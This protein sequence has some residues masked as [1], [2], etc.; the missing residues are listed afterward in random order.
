[1]FPEGQHPWLLLCALADRMVHQALRLTLD[2][3]TYSI[4]PPLSVYQW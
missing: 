1:M 3:N 2:Q 4:A